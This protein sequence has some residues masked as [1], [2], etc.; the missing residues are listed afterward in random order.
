MT[1][2]GDRIGQTI[3]VLVVATVIALPAVESAPRP[4]RIAVWFIL[5]VAWTGLLAAT[6]AHIWGA[7]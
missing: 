6:V 2:A 1:D 3:V 4:A 7:L 5:S